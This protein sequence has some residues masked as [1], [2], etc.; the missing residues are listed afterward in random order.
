M[1]TETQSSFR[2][3]NGN[4]GLCEIQLKQGFGKE[5]TYRYCQF[6]ER[7]DGTIAHSTGLNRKLG[8]SPLK[9]TCVP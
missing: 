1:Q 4:A 5:K 3:Q 9:S 2:G 8:G 7:S 6:S